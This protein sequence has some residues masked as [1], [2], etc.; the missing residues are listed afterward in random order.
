LTW[1]PPGFC[2]GRGDLIEGL[3]LGYNLQMVALLILYSIGVVEELKAISFTDEHVVFTI[4]TGAEN[5]GA[6]PSPVPFSYS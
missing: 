6:V 3:S 5:P 2:V 1:F 4:V